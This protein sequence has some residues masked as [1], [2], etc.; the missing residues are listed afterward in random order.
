MTTL[1]FNANDYEPAQDRDV[2]PPDIYK[3][4]IIDS[5]IAP[6]KD[7]TGKRLNLVF[8]IVEGK[9]KGRKI[10]EGL[11]VVNKS[12]ETM[13]IAF[14]QLSAICRCVGKL[15]IKDS[16][17]LHH[18]PIMIRVAVRPASG[19]YSASNEIKGYKPVEGSDEINLEIKKAQEA[20]MADPA[21]WD[22]ESA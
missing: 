22:S 9:F 4:V 15:S 21:P 17:E 14:A 20:I 8:E 2:I 19:Q 12:Q 5:K 16:S 18:L 13:D 6:T 10:F 11:N 7:G 3:A 1:N